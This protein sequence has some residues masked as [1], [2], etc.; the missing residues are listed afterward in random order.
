MVSAGRPAAERAWLTSARTWA[1][2]LPTEVPAGF[3]AD[4]AGGGDAELADVDADA[5]DRA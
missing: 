3:V 5:D 1:A 4:G 2:A